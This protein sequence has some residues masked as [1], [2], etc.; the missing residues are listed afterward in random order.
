MTTWPGVWKAA[1]RFQRGQV[2]PKRE[3]GKLVAGIALRDVAGRIDPQ[4]EEGHAARAGAAE[5][6]QAVRDL[7]DVGAELR[8]TAGRSNS[9]APRRLEEA[10]VGHHDR[11]GRIIGEA[12]VEQLAR[13]PSSGGARLRDHSLEHGRELDQRQLIGEGEGAV[14]GPQQRRDQEHPPLRV[15]MLADIAEQLGRD[16]PRLDPQ[17]FLQPPPH[18]LG[19]RTA[20]R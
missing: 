7:L 20:D 9:D 14:F 19:D 4:H 15:V 11:P 5:R 17:R 18:R 6:R 2:P 13:V 16:D 3:K 1:W 12:H 10:A 8:R